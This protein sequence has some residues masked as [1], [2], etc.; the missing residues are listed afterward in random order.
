MKNNITTH[1]KTL[2]HKVENQHSKLAVQT[3]MLIIK[4]FK[5][6]KNTLVF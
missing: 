4:T 5:R 3:S 6:I 2:S 1:L